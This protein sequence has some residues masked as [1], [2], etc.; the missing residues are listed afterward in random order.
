MDR[1]D[2]AMLSFLLAH[3][4]VNDVWG[5]VL[6]GGWTDTMTNLL[7]EIW[8]KSD[9]YKFFLFLWN[10]LHRRFFQLLQVGPI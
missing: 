7:A 1:L 2:I 5:E 10:K 6:A 3:S 9:I 8:Q 4:G